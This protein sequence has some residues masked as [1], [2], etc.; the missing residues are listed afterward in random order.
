[1]KRVVT[2]QRPNWKEHAEGLGFKLHT[3]FDKP[4]WNE[5]VHYSFTLEQVEK[6]LE[7][8]STEL[9]AMCLQAVEH[10][11][12]RE[13]LLDQMQIPEAHWDYVL[14][15]WNTERNQTLYGRFDLAYNGQGPAKMLE[16][17]ADTP[18]SLYEAASYQ[19]LWLEEAKRHSIIGDV[20]QF[21]AIE[22]S[23][24]QEMNKYDNR[25]DFYFSSFEGSDEDYMTVEYMGYCA[26]DAGL[27]A[28]Y[29]PLQQI[30]EDDKGQFR[31]PDGKLIEQL[32]MLYPWEDMLLDDYSRLLKNSVTKFV[33][34]AWKTILSNKGILPVLWQMFEGHPNLLPAFFGEQKIRGG[35]VTKPI[36]SRE[37]S[38]IT[39]YK[40]GE[41]WM[42]DDQ[43]YVKNGMITQGYVELPNFDG[44]RPVIGTWIVGDKCVGMGIRE[45]ENEITQ[46]LSRFT[47]HIII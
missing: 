41:I 8:P 29:I 4:Y 9:H 30:S 31:T 5:G 10:V 14:N 6:D 17:N 32:F 22:D 27:T 28:Q 45:D 16:Y 24:I 38:S 25:K 19:W 20:D 11:V 47:P 37:G 13:E 34:P 36:Y 15:S 42:A 21:N 35:Y 46:D 44:N 33:E 23:L 12:N 18:T 40:D 3:M 2:E 43:S 39:I 7:D 1:M 26:V